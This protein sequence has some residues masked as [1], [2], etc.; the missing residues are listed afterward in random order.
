MDDF[1]SVITQTADQASAEEPAAKG[2]VRRCS[3]FAAGDLLS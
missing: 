1:I 3:A 2:G